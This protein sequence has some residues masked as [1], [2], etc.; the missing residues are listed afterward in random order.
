MSR[1]PPGRSSQ[2]SQGLMPYANGGPP[3]RN[4]SVFVPPSRPGSRME[5]PPLS[6]TAGPMPGTLERPIAGP[7]K[8]L[9]VTCDGTW[10]DSDNGITNGQ[11]TPPSNVSRIGWAMKDTSRDG[12]PQVVHYQAGVGTM[13]GPFS[14]TIGGATGIGLK[15]NVR[16]AYSYLAINWREGDE[17]FLLG[18]SRGAFTARSV[19]GLIGE[20]GLLTRAGL[21]YVSSAVYHPSFCIAFF[22]E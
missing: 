11:L 21:P 12:I 19:G 13:G 7:K 14:R 10:L 4:S 1:P 2:V 15:E 3:P 18:F 6:A 20:L 17:I 22:R 16:E 9:I 8:R 5:P